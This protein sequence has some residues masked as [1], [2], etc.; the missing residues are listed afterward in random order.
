MRNELA[1]WAAALAAGALLLLC[2]SGI[3]V[4]Q[5]HQTPL[6]AAPAEEFKC[7]A[8]TKDSGSVPGMV[9]RWCEI[10]RGG[11]LLYHGPVWRWHPNGQMEGKEYY[12][13]GDAE[14][15]WPSWYENGNRSS[16]GRFSKG[17]K[18]GLWKYWDS[19]GWLKTEVT[20]T[21]KGDLRTDYYASGQKKATGTF[22]ETGKIGQWVYWDDSGKEKAQCDFGEGLFTLPSKDCELIAKDLDPEGFS[23]PVPVGRKPDDRHVEIRIASEVYSFT[24][25]TGWV[26]DVQAGKEEGAPAVLFPR[27]S[28]WRKGTNIYIRPV[29]KSGH[30]FQEAVDAEKE[31]FQDDV[32]D[33]NEKLGASGH[34][35]SG[36]G[37][38]FKTIAYKPL[39]ATDSPFSIVASNSIHEKV[40]FLDASGEVVLLVVLTANSQAEMNRFT[41]QLLSV[42]HSFR[43]QKN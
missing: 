30:T 16:L 19:D 36:E 40:A 42:V 20:Y 3:A 28:D 34:L 13:Y 21:D 41:P 7:P 12:I 15:E 31:C 38:M 4:G 43:R 29:F 9:V 5:S 14:G 35:T 27:G 17:K 24:T 37:Y 22:V 33:Y 10:W 11:R 6:V 32:A 2:A 18:T 8:G 1:N 39:I 26:G 23:T 25:P